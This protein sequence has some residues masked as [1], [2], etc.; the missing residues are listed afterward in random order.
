MGPWLGLGVG[1][2]MRPKVCGL[3]ILGP[4]QAQG[5]ER[6]GASDDPM[7]LGEERVP[8]QVLQTLPPRA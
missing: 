2:G 8:V 7:Q 4:V 6:I 5:E 3:L 1:L